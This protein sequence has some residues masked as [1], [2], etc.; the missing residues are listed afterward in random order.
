M[1]LPE[2]PPGVSTDGVRAPARGGVL[3]S[4]LCPVCQKVP[5]HASQE[6]C[7]GRCRAARSRQR[8]AE[9]RGERDAE[10]RGLLKAALEK[11]QEGES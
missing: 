1:S 4:R 10:I 11:L 7:S 8:K 2:T 6:V 9:A 5:I 3:A